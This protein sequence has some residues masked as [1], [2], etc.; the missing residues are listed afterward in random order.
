MIITISSRIHRAI[1]HLSR[2]SS[3]VP[4]HTH[5]GYGMG[6]GVGGWVGGIMTFVTTTGHIV[7]VD[8][9]HHFITH[10]SCHYSPL[11]H[12]IIRSRTYAR[13]VWYGGGGGWVGGGDN[14]VRYNYWTHCVR[15]WSSPFHHAFILPLLTSHALHHSFPHIRMEGMVWGGGGWVGGGDNDI[16]YNYWTHCVRQWSSP[17]HHAFILP[18][19]T[20]HA[21]HHSFPHIRMEGMVWGGGVGGWVGGIMTFGTTTG[22][23][24]S[25]NDHHHFIT[26][27]SC[28]YSPLTHFIIRSRR[29]NCIGFRNIK[30]VIIVFIIIII[31]NISRALY[32]KL[33]AQLPLFCDFVITFRWDPQKRSRSWLQFFTL[34]CIHCW[35]GM[36]CKSRLKGSRQSRCANSKCY[37]DGSVVGI[38]T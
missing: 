5:G 22:H 1:T 29:R 7:S 32:G 18:L 10:S 33:L 28:H 12:F 35:A 23:I 3:F 8:D 13:R 16:R 6:G 19:L 14:D 38:Y 31:R 21:L 30:V 11:T 2:T 34:G 37:I 15:R 36:L 9:H 17:F 27:S 24:V 25:V 20:S 4:A 26:H